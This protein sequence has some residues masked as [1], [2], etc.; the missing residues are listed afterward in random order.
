[1]T[2]PT[3]A[4]DPGTEPDVLRIANCSGF[5]GDRLS[6]A[7][8]M[9]DGGP[10]EERAAQRHADPQGQEDRGD[11]DDVVAE[12]DHRRGSVLVSGARQDD[13]SRRCTGQSRPEGERSVGDARPVVRVDDN[14]HVLHERMRF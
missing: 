8:E 14:L 4:A 5:Y 13:S 12:V 7:R 9:V 11:G 1:M 6:A 3:T 10:I 2:D